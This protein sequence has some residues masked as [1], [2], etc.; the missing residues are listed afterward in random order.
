M[1]ASELVVSKMCSHRSDQSYTATSGL[2][3]CYFLSDLDGQTAV[4]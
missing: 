2:M 3:A 1:A 4:I